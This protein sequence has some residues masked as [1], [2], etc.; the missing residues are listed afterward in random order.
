MKFA[1]AILKLRPLGG[2]ERDFIGLVEQFRARGHAIHVIV[3]ETP[4]MSFD[5]NVEVTV[6]SLAAR[7]NHSRH[8][9][10]AEAVERM[11]H[12]MA[13]DTVLVAFDR[14][15]S[16][17]YLFV[18]TRPHAPS[19]HWKRHLPRHRALIAL[20]Q[21]TFSAQGS[22]FA[23][24][25]THDQA[26]RYTSHYGIAPD[27]Y[28]VLPLTF[29]V[30]RSLPTEYYGARAQVRRELGISNET[31]LLIHVAV[32]GRL[33]GLDRAID[34]LPELP[35]V[36]LLVIGESGARFRRQARRRSVDARV[37][38][39]GYASD[40]PHFLGAADVLV[41]PA[42]EENTGTVILESLLYGVP[43]IVS[44]ECGYAEHVAR[45]GAGAVI[46]APFDQKDFLGQVQS[47]LAPGR[48]ERLRAAARRFGPQLVSQG[49]IEAVTEAML[50]TISERTAAKAS[51][52]TVSASREQQP[53]QPVR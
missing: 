23:F 52:A 10:F 16:A 29:G 27:R 9:A 15:P 31:P 49:G 20:E 39:V 41:H 43:A 40:L 32:N 14:V 18:T 38:F 4:P 12:T 19:A 45:S 8:R 1:F 17:D 25:L 11:R 3:S 48:L 34:L 13:S 6:A 22:S 5:P 24:F 46:P 44:A 51:P 7:T 37:H 35:D 47:A 21:A 33:K 28:A 30:G 26:A 36:H 50:A 53:D 2:K 42:R